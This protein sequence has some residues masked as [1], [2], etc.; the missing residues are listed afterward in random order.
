MKPTSIEFKASR[1]VQRAHDDASYRNVSDWEDL[2]MGPFYPL[3]ACL[4]DVKES[5]LSKHGE[6]ARITSTLSVEVSKEPRAV[7]TV[8][9]YAARSTGKFGATRIAESSVTIQMTPLLAGLFGAGKT[10]EVFNSSTPDTL[11]STN[12]LMALEQHIQAFYSI[13]ELSPQHSSSHLRSRL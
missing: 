10:R 6:N 13:G 12:F 7:L 9:L 8:R 5:I 2:L 3:T 1:G 4:N 11:E